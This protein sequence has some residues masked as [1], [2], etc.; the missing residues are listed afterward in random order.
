MA[1]IGSLAFFIFALDK[2]VKS[3]GDMKS[4][5]SDVASGLNNLVSKYL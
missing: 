5:V 3:C 1:T 2:W 4:V